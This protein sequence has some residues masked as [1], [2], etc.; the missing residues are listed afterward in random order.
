MKHLI[1]TSSD[2]KYGD[3]LVNHW[4]VSLKENVNLTNVDVIV[5]DYGLEEKHIQALTNSNVIVI[6]CKKDGH[7]TSLRY[8][9]LLTVLRKNKYDQVLMVDG[10]DIIFQD[11]F[12]EIF[13]THKNMF[14]VVT[15]DVFVNFE[16]MYKHLI[17]SEVQKHAVIDLLAGKRAINGGFVVAPSSLF[18]NF[19]R[20][21]L[22]K[23]KNLGSYGID[24]V[25]LNYYLYENGF[26]SIDPTYNFMLISK[27]H[28]D[29]YLIKNNCF[30]SKKG[31]LIKVVH[32]LGGYKLIRGMNQFGYKVTL[33]QNNLIYISKIGSRLVNKIYKL[34]GK[35]R[36]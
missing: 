24:Q 13:K 1:V 9:D 23:I 8:R 34:I 21:Y 12:T 35:F 33:K 14:R 6:K 20:Y 26:V 10:G 2:S 11:D 7:V 18:V 32:N 27:F 36:K 4:L 17:K 16:H 19:C 28:T 5:L 3:F 22:N 29:R 31:N 15:E 25:I 30:Y